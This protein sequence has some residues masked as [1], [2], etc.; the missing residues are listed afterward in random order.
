[1]NSF[2]PLPPSPWTVYL[3][4]CW[5]YL[6]FIIFKDNIF[7]EEISISRYSIFH[8]VQ[9]WRGYIYLIMKRMWKWSNLKLLKLWLSCPKWFEEMKQNWF[10]P[11]PSTHWHF[12]LD[13][14]AVFWTHHTVTSIKSALL[15][16]SIAVYF[17]LP[18]ISS[19]QGSQLFSNRKCIYGEVE[20]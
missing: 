15:I 5:M 12:I 20:F 17:V 18:E 19:V 13:H 3:V 7:Q 8:I 10:P 11:P 1:M 6:W 14:H 4:Y 9:N 16:V 2:I